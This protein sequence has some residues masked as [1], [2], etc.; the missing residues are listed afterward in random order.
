MVVFAYEYGSASR[1]FYAPPWDA[2][3]EVQGPRAG[4]APARAPLE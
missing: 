1:Y 4:E 3:V 2:T